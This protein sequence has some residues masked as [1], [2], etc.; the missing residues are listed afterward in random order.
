MKHRYEDLDPGLRRMVKAIRCA[1][2]EPL[3]HNFAARVTERVMSGHV[4]P[5]PWWKQ[6]AE[7]LSALFR[8][9]TVIIRPAFQLAWALLLCV[10]AS[11]VTVWTAGGVGSGTEDSILVRFAV[12]VPDARQVGVAGDFNEWNAYR[13]QLEDRDGDG[14]WHGLV[15]VNPGVHQYMF[16]I[17]GQKWMT[18]PLSSETVDDGFGQ[19]NSLIRV[20]CGRSDARAGHEI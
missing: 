20:E 10:L 2:P 18:D 11:G 6:L 3:R 9:R 8:P 7:Y 5:R 19:R 15:P 14:V 4:E 16:V 17:D 13:T 12:R 1:P